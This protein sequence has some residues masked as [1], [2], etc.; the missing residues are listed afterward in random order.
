[1]VKRYQKLASGW[2]LIS[3]DG[4]NREATLNGANIRLPSALVQDGPFTG[5]HTTL[6]GVW[7]SAVLAKLRAQILVEDSKG[8]RQARAEVQLVPAEK[9]KSGRLLELRSP[10]DN[11]NKEPDSEI[12]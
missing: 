6:S 9:M 4:H 10:I 7:R 5:S 12:L 8:G 3:T 2:E 11:K 1:M